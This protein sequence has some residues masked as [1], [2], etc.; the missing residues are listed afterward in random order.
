MVYVT[1]FYYAE[2]LIYLIF[3]ILIMEFHSAKNI[4]LFKKIIL[5][6]I[7]FKI[8]QKCIGWNIFS[9][10]KNYNGLLMCSA[11]CIHYICLHILKFWKEKFDDEVPR[12]MSLDYF[13]SYPNLY[14]RHTDSFICILCWQYI[15]LIEGLRSML[16]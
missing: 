5:Q 8:Q 15:Y 2:L 16:G 3:S 7:W 1:L 13:L 14:R 4:W 6:Q 12:W 9:W 11:L 10:K